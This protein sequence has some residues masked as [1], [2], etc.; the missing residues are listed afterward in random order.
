V[1]GVLSILTLYTVLNL[2]RGFKDFRAGVREE[3]RG[4]GLQQRLLKRPDDPDL[5]FPQ[6]ANRAAEVAEAY[7]ELNRPEAAEAV[8]ELE[9]QRRGGAA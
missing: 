8:L 1:R 4:W 6:D 7:L 5:H 2:I 9:R 3:R